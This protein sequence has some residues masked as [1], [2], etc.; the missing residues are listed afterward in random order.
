MSAPPGIGLYRALLRFYPRRFRDEYDKDM[1]VLFADQLQDEPGVRV[2]ARGMV[3]LAVTVPTRHLEAHMSRLPSPT[4][5][6][7]FGAVSVA[8]LLFGLLAGSNLGML[9]VGLSVA[10]V[11]GA[12]AVVGWRYNRVISTARPATAHWWKFLAGGAGVLAVVVV[13]TTT[14]GEVDE[15]LWWPMLITVLS[16]LGAVAAGLVLG[17]AR[18]TRSRGGHAGG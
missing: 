3:D 12:L 15:S 10:A 6:L 17:I 8:G 11:A 7:L 5:P 9:G 16:A 13:V 4:T 2:W 14:T 1:A 18:L